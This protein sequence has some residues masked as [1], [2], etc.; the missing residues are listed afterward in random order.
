MEVL[1]ENWATRTASTTD[2]IEPTYVDAPED[3]RTTLR[4]GVAAL[5]IKGIAAN[6]GRVVYVREKTD[7]HYYR[8]YGL[9]S[10]WIVEPL[11]RG[12]LESASGPVINGFIPS[13]ALK[14]L[15][16]TLCQVKKM[17]DAKIDADWN[18]A[19]EELKV[20]LADY[21]DSPGKVA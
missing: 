16:L 5:I 21:I 3:C 10:C 14:P 1:I 15:D 8:G 17:R 13:I 19:I 7:D 4:P 18:A 20:V 6:I 12:D 9:L 11:S 2:D